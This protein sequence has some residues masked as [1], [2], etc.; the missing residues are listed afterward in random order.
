MRDPDAV[1]VA[2]RAGLQGGKAKCAEQQCED[3]SEAVPKR[4]HAM[5]RAHMRREMPYTAPSSCS[6]TRPSPTGTD[7]QS[8]TEKLL[9]PEATPE[10]RRKSNTRAPLRSNRDSPPLA[11]SPHTPS[12]AQGA[13]IPRA[14]YGG[15]NTPR[16]VPDRRIA[17]IASQPAPCHRWREEG[18]W[19]GPLASLR[20]CKFYRFASLPVKR[21]LRVR[22]SL[23][24]HPARDP[25]VNC[26]FRSTTAIM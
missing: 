26:R 11:K 19:L 5:K 2:Q 14:L 7:A 10:P 16:G 24:G 17:R 6:T 15:S 21:R 22:S 8:E 20:E 25:G 23:P 12:D 4:P 9:R 13:P 18:E 3:R 1:S